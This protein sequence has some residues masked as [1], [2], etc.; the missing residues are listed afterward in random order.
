MRNR[1]GKGGREREKGERAKA[2][3]SH[4]LWNQS[5]YE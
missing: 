1:V 2:Y 4:F 5:G 3:Q